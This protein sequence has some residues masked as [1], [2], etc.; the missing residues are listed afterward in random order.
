M[1]N[2]PNQGQ[3]GKLSW[4]AFHPADFAGETQNLTNAQV[5]SY[6]RLVCY[7]AQ[8]G[9][10]PSDVSELALIARSKSAQEW[11]DTWRRLAPLFAPSGR[12][13]TEINKAHAAREERA[14]SGRKGGLARASKAQ[15]PL[16]VRQVA[17]LNQP[18]PEPQPDPDQGRGYQEGTPSIQGS[19]YSLEGFATVQEEASTRGRRANGH[20]GSWTGEAE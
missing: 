20:G 3:N 13:A 5:G 16:P 4:F 11:R 10:L 18:E 9:D 15:A 12:L 7:Y 1:G 17:Q 8:M 2:I 6:F 19:S 14:A